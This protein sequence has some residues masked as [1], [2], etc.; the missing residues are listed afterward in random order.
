M[1]AQRIGRSG[2]QSL[3][4]ADIV[5]A[6]LLAFKLL[7]VLFDQLERRIGDVLVVVPPLAH[8]AVR[9]VVDL[10]RVRNVVALPGI[11]L[12][13]IGLLL[14]IGQIALADIEQPVASMRV[15][16]EISLTK[17]RAAA[18]CAA[19][20]ISPC[21]ASCTFFGARRGFALPIVTDEAVTLLSRPTV[22]WLSRNTSLM[23]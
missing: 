4:H 11:G 17:S 7:I 2:R 10:G 15:D 22:T 16:P 18:V 1:A 14:D 9:I 21:S 20:R 3:V 6:R 8:Q 12:V 19:V 5:E 23:N 13:L